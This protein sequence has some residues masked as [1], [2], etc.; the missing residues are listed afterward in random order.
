MAP[1]AAVSVSSMRVLLGQVRGQA[2]AESSENEEM[3]PQ[4]N[5]DE[6]ENRRADK[7]GKRPQ[8]DTD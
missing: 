7:T 1:S 5:A 2:I 6:R 3:E 8:I 4:I